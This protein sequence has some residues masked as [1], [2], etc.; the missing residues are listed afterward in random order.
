MSAENKY[1]P[2]EDNLV[3]HIKNT[4][5]V[6]NTEKSKELFSLVYFCFKNNLDY[7]IIISE[8]VSKYVYSGYKNECLDN[9]LFNN[10][11][12]KKYNICLSKAGIIYIESKKPLKTRLIPSSFTDLLIKYF[13]NKKTT[14]KFNYKSIDVD[15]KIEK[16]FSKFKRKQKIIL[17]DEIKFVYTSLSL[18]GITSSPLARRLQR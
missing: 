3:K 14:I 15:N 11:T 10:R 16:E 7:N 5:T 2:E 8:N 6:N 4:Y 9:S 12:I 1:G 18:E 17:S 13:L